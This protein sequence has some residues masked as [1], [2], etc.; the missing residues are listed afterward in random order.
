MELFLKILGLILMTAGAA[1]VFAAKPICKGMD[2]AKKQV[3][4][5]EADKGTIE[6]LKE[7]KAIMK[8]KLVGGAVFLPGM[9]LIV[10]LFR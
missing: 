9:A 5:L 7:Q 3:I 2:L 6:K 4:K 8:I 10:Y 1:I